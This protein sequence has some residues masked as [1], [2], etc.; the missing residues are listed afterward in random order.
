M[1]RVA[2][3]TP[4]NFFHLERMCQ[5]P[6]HAWQA[7]LV[8]HPCPFLSIT[9][10]WRGYPWFEQRYQKEHRHLVC[11]DSPDPS[12]LNAREAVR[13]L[14][15]SLSEQCRLELDKRGLAV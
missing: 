12:R 15:G 2:Y 4:R 11:V 3:R 9:R 7:C 13:Q 8:R 5:R 1:L 10:L 14:D 6:S